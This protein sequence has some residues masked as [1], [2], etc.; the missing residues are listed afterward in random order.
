V[1]E[2]IDPSGGFRTTFISR[3]KSVGQPTEL[4]SSLNVQNPELNHGIPNIRL[5]RSVTIPP[6]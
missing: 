3:E 1:D 4:A 6:L 2:V 5:I